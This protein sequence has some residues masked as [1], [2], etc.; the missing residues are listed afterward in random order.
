MS[1]FGGH[2]SIHPPFLLKLRLRHPLL[3]LPTCTPHGYAWVIPLYSNSVQSIHSFHFALYPSIPSLV[4]YLLF[5]FLF[6]NLSSSHQYF[7]FSVIFFPLFKYYIITCP[8]PPPI[9]PP[10]SHQF[11][12]DR[13]FFIPILLISFPIT[14]PS[15][16]P[17]LESLQHHINTTIGSFLKNHFWTPPY[18]HLLYKSSF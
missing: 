14:T 3:L 9:L 10:Y 7:T 4:Y 2:S 12:F 17:S 16:P 15:S 18:L 8:S 11:P 1:T 5:C 6:I 13:Y